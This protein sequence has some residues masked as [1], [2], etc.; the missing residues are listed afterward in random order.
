MQRDTPIFVVKDP[1]IFYYRLKKSKIKLVSFFCVEHN[2]KPLVLLESLPALLKA[3][4]K[5]YKSPNL[6]FLMSF[7]PG[8]PKVS[9]YEGPLFLCF[10]FEIESNEAGLSFPLLL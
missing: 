3:K 9:F 7:F 4:D 2:L 8:I 1:G 10:L 5:K 6:I